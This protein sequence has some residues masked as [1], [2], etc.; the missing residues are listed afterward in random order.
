MARPEKSNLTEKY[1]RQQLVFSDWYLRLEDYL[2]KT[3]FPIVHDNPKL[4]AE[5]HR[6]YDLVEEMLTNGEIPLAETGP[7]LDLE[8]QQINTVI[9][10]HTEED[11]NI[12]LGRLNAIGL[13]R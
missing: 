8:R 3:I 12:T 1:L 11:P 9:I 6:F 2:N 13:I 7:N 5:R 4:K 10:H